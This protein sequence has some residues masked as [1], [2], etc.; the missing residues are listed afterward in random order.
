MRLSLQILA[1]GL[2][3]GAVPAAGQPLRALEIADLFS[4]KRIA[5]PAVSPD[6]ASVVYNLTT[7]DLEANSNGTDLWI[8]PA[9]G[10]PPRQLT[11]HTAFDGNAAWSPDGRWLA[12]ESARSGT[13]QIWLLATGGGEPHQ[14]TSLSTGATTPVW[15]PDGE[16]IAF[17]SDVFP[18]YSEKPFLESDALNKARL[19]NL[20]KGK[21]KARILTRLLYRH[22]DSWVDGKR[23]HV[24]LQA[25]RGGEPRDLTPGDRDAVPTSETFSGGTDFAFSPDGKEIAFTA[26]PV[27]SREEAW[28]TNHDIFIVPAGG[29]PPRQMTTN[30]AADGCPRYSPDGAFIAY[31]AQRRAGFEADR[32]ELMLRERSTGLTRS[33]TANFD[34][35]VGTPVWAPDSKKLYFEAE[36]RACVP[37]F[38]VSI[39]G[40][41]VAM[42]IGNAT[43]HDLSVTADGRRLFFTRVKA[44][45]PPEIYRC[46]TRGKNL[47]AVTGVNDSVFARLDVPAPESVWFAGEGGKS[48]QAWIYKPPQFDPSHVHPLVYMVHG[49]PQGAWLDSWSYRWNPPL[50]AA[51]GYVVVAPNPRGSTGFGQKFTDEISGDWGGKVFVDLMKGLDFAESLAY[52]DRGRTA[53]AGASFGGYMMNWFLGNASGRFR[54]IV[55]HDGVYNFE[56]NYGTTDE[57]WFD[58][59]DHRG[60]P[61]QRP[62][63]YGR[64]SPHRYAGNF[65]TPTLVIHGALDFRVPESEG[66]Q[67]FTALQKQG[68]PS[69]FLYFPDEGHWVL[70]PANSRLWHETVFSWLAQYLK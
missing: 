61:W 69:K 48:V 49:G 31:R 11:T 8:S 35:H 47:A 24:F 45:R 29:G 16:S 34:S 10:G 50:W 7:P 66:M 59:W 43:H 4:M 63:E 55:S 46:D 53:A 13:S 9:A 5:A 44:T 6:G 20:Q 18:E 30:P 51:Q 28:S 56:S 68:V 19:D 25:I 27:P 26:T 38:S 39:K 15:S 70:K 36:D 2:I 52:V 65:A 1:G 62:E 58:E 21:V 67:L 37:L 32:W 64:F 57:I 33:L 54:A 3:V 41:D 14:F 40:D 60:S 22:W 42:V 12:F 23:R 17:V